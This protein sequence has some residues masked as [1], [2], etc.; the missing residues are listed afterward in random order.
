MIMWLNLSACQCSCSSLKRLQGAVMIRRCRRT[1]SDDS[2]A[3]GNAADSVVSSQQEP[4]ERVSRR[5]NTI[6]AGMPF[7]DTFT[8]KVFDLA[9]DGS[10]VLF[11]PGGN[12][13]P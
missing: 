7:P 8:E 1:E 4:E 6:L 13:I 9:V 10:E 3:G 12:F 2:C 11:G 5:K